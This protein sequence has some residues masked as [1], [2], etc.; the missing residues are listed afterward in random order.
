M[1]RIRLFEEL[2]AE[3][4]AQLIKRTML[5]TNIKDYSK[6]YVEADLQRLTAQDLINRAKVFHCYIVV[7]DIRNRITAVGSI[8]PYWGKMMRVVFLIS[9]FRRVI[10]AK[11]LDAN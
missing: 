1:I 4:V 6:E 8:G 2:D 7:D 3:E 11:A 9:L 10:K 5:T